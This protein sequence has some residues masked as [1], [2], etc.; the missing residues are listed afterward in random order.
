MKLFAAIL[1]SS[2]VLSTAGVHGQQ[3]RHLRAGRQQLQDT[4]DL[5]EMEGTPFILGD[6][7]EYRDLLTIGAS[8]AVAQ[9][10]SRFQPQERRRVRLIN[11]NIPKYRKVLRLV[12]K[13]FPWGILIYCRFF[14][15]Q[16]FI[17]FEAINHGCGI[18][19]GNTAA[20]TTNVRQNVRLSDYTSCDLKI[21][22]N[23]QTFL[24]GTHALSYN[25]F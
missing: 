18:R 1:V 15:R 14:L 3:Y 10:A 19:V 23:W 13:S 20:V 25:C 8:R 21:H 16:F 22:E 9:Y 12:I 5:G 2:A 24:N 7:T 17:S 4:N 6:G 11:Y